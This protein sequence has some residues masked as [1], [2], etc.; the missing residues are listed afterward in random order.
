MPKIRNRDRARNLFRE[1]NN[2]KKFE[3]ADCKVAFLSL[4]NLKVR[5][6]FNAKVMDPILPHVFQ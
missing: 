3:C 4:W 1:L 6:L 5:L 2:N